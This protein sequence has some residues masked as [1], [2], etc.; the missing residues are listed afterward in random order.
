[1]RWFTCTPRNFPGDQGFFDRESG[2]LS[3]GFQALGVE[4]RAVVLGPAME[5][6]LPQMIRAT[7]E[8]LSSADWWRGHKLDGVVF[9]CWGEPEFQP[10]A[11][12]IVAAGIRLASVSDTHGVCSP[13]A[14]AHGH[15]ISAWHHQWQD[16]FLKKLVRTVLRVPYFYTAGII[17]YDVP[18]ARMI[19]TGDFFLGA[20]PESAARYRRLVSI[21][22]GGEAAA[23]VRFLPVPVSFHFAYDPAGAKQD[24]VV[25][26]GRWDD[27][28]QKRP[29]LLMEVFER[30]A[31]RRKETRFR[32]F[33]RTPGF[34]TVWHAGLPEEIRSRIVLEGIQP[35]DVIAAAYQRA[36][37]M[38]VSAAY[39]GCHNAS[40]E[41]VCSGCTV[42]GA[43]SPFLSAIKW[44][45][46]HDSGTLAEDASPAALAGALC[47]E[48]EIWDRKERDPGQISR[49]WCSEMHPEKVAAAILALFGLK[50]PEPVPVSV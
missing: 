13:L 49:S 23:K 25:A 32:I 8:E 10:I 42:V 9:Y 22:R 40:A 6:D 11:D 27:R 12:A 35:H 41:A 26:V 2:L 1:M 45:A 39:E 28:S 29:A 7:A 33:G 3:R 21:L 15:F 46:S 18:R 4:S 44:H 47:A 37:T 38:F 43:S 5:G 14:D 34:M 16:P 24:E 36:R 20:T 48:L 19:D 31:A 50:A 30:T 17:R